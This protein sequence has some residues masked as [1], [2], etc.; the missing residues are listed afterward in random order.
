MQLTNKRTG[1]T[2]N[3]RTTK[4]NGYFVSIVERIEDID[5]SIFGYLSS[6]E[7]HKTR[8]K[9][10]HYADSMARYQFRT[11]CAIYGI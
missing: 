3:T 6:R 1:V 9:A 11:H 7:K 10:R 2:F 5:G 8:G 4:E